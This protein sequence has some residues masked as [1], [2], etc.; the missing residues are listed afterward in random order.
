MV[1]NILL[2]FSMTCC[3]Q[4]GSN[5]SDEIPLK[6]V[7]GS[8]RISSGRQSDMANWTV[9]T[10]ERTTL[11]ARTALVGSNG[12]FELSH[13]REDRPRTIA[14]LSP[15]HILRSMLSI[16]TASPTL[17]NQYFSGTPAQ[18]PPLVD[19]GPIV[20]FGSLDGITPIPDSIKS[21]RGDGVPN[22]AYGD[23]GYGLIDEGSRTTFDPNG[24][25]EVFNP[26]RNSDGILDIFEMDVNANRKADA[27]EGFGPNFY[28]EGLEY[29]AVQYELASDGSGTETA[30]ILF[31]AKLKP[32]LK[33]QDIQ[34]HGSNNITSGASTVSGGVSGA[35]DKTL[36]DDGGS[37]DSIAGDNIF[38]RRITL[39]SATRLKSYEVVIFEPRRADG[40][41]N[42][43]AQPVAG[44]KYPVTAPPLT[45]SALSTPVWD[46][47]TRTI[48][49]AGNP[50]GTV[51]A[52][53]W[54]VT[55]YDANSKPV[56]NSNAVDGSEDTLILPDNAFDS[57]GSYT[58]KV[59]ARCQE[60]VPGYS[61]FVVTSPVVSL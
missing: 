31:S 24:L 34:I 26:D 48:N 42:P 29:A 17:I 44:S 32:G 41:S 25:P 10:L 20:V 27:A 43:S 54:S 53:T 58:A 35:W 3:S 7:S 50:F 11:N 14:L 47:V 6:Q 30:Q 8:I 40:E 45:V 1:L 22:S 2:F 57:T 36:L 5:S 51:T 59:I 28:S 56:Y 21:D 49:R 18:L 4:S 33:V 23:T 55:V 15:D 61:F 60:Q 12:T 16:P 52:Y 46:S 19:R 13:V 38:A 9:L 39:S 37:D